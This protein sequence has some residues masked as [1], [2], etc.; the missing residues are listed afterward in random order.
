M[1][2]INI[3]KI[4]LPALILLMLF[5]SA[6]LI[7]RTELLEGPVIFSPKTLLSNTW[8][9]Y[10]ERYLEQDTYRTVD[11]QRDNITTS[12]GQSYT[13]IRAVW[14]DDKETFDGAWQWSQD[15]LQREKDSLF[16]WL[17]GERSDGT[18]GVLIQENG[19]NTASDADVDIALSLLFAYARWQDTDYLEDAREIIND[20]WEKEVVIIN[21][22]PYIASSNVDKEI[23]ASEIVMNPSYFAPYAYRIFKDVDP[24]HPWDE[25]AETSYDV[26]EESMRLSLDSENS[27]NIPPNWISINTAT[28]EIKRAE[29]LPAEIKN[30]S[31]FGFDAMRIPWRIALDFKWFREPRAEELLEEMEFFSKEWGANQ[32][33]NAEYTHA[34]VPAEYFESSA[35]Y[36]G[37]IGYFVV[38]EP[39]IADAVYKDKLTVLYNPDFNDWSRPLNYYDENW[40]WFGIALYNDLLPNLWSYV[41]RSVQ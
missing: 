4:I 14:M 23:G 15:N 33:I 22:K 3:K 5:T 28:G 30:G 1:T 10:K 32:K 41:D 35:I 26:L 2:K 38:S 37:L 20:I 31:N 34:G 17:F 13:M 12:E 19:L 7:I 40:A 9:R 24:Q 25:L 16:S 11:R 39:E 18:Y 27:A 6:I 21:G 36:G 29:N 8:E